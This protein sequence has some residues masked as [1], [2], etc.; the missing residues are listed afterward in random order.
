MPTAT[1]GTTSIDIVAPAADVYDL[2]TDVARIGERSPECYRAEWLDGAGAAVVGARFRGHNR[3]GPIKWT[4][5]CTVT[6][7]DRGR[8]FA[9]SVIAGGGRE[10]TRWRYLLE[11]TD[12]GCRL[13]ESYEFVWCP[14]IARIAELPF[15][16]DRQLRH[17]IRRTVEAIKSTA[18]GRHRSRSVQPSSRLPAGDA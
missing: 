2:V 17:G 10:S 9:F 18:E 15:P 1:H 14:R 11:D 16:R 6:T 13:T 8:E 12:A 7:A 3:I 5:T 4:T